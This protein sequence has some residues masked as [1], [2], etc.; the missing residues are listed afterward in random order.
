[1]PVNHK[2]LG[3]GII[4]SCTLSGCGAIEFV[5]TPESWGASGGSYGAKQF[6]ETNGKGN[7]PTT[8]SAALYCA[9]I[10]EAGQKKFNWTYEQVLKAA[11][12]CTEA[13]VE[14]L[15]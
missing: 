2:V 1:M 12:A 9:D 10:S 14:G 8:E 13:F 11:D 15:K 5:E 4:L 7:W 6:I 3:F